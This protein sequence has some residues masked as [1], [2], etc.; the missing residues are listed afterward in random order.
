MVAPLL[1]AGLGAAGA[2]GAGLLSA[3]G[4]E[5]ANRR[6]IALAR[7]QMRFQERMSGS[8]FQ[9]AV[10]DMKLA[11]INPMLAYAQGGASSPSGQTAR[12]EDVL[13][14]AVSSAM[15]V[16]RMKKELKLLDQQTYNQRMLGYKAM[17]EGSYVNTQNQILGA[18]VLRGTQITPYGVIQK[19]LDTALRQQQVHL[20]Q[21]Q[22][23][24]LQYSPLM[25]KF[26]GVEGPRM[27]FEDWRKTWN[28][29]DRY[30]RP[31]R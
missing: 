1:A 9:R 27:F 11:G 5:R 6:N 28:F 26:T 17:A 21:A 4:Q 18:G 14:P 25:T 8:S 7:E 3:G 24:A 12:T 30:D 16:M 20:T 19:R 31:R 22:A 2:I 13:G 10:R 15:S 23:R 29:R